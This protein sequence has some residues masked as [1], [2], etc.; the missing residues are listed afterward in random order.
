M[1]KIPFAGIELT[2]QRVRGYMVPL[3]YDTGATGMNRIK[4]SRK[5]ESVQRAG[6]HTLYGPGSGIML[7]CC[8]YT[9]GS[10]RKKVEI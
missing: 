3:S 6:S 7:V 1:R 9:G 4:K 5:N 10:S 8:Q 2:S